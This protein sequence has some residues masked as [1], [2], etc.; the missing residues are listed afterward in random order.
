MSRLYSSENI[1]Y[2]VLFAY[3][4]LLQTLGVIGY[5]LLPLIVTGALLPL[6]KSFALVGDA[7]QVGRRSFHVELFF[8]FCHRSL[9]VLARGSVVVLVTLRTHCV[10]LV[11]CY[12]ILQCRVDP[13]ASTT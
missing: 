9:S 13:I 7:V 8:I 10:C 12:C 4:V 11:I 3:Y 5:S 2:L 6:V 1:T